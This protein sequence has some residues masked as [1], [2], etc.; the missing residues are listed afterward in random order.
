MAKKFL[1]AIRLL[2]LAEDPVSASNGDLY[3]NSSSNLAKLYSNGSWVNVPKNVEDLNNVSASGLSNNQILVYNQSL[4][5]W[6][7]DNLPPSAADSGTSLPQSATNG[8]FF[9]HTV[10]E[11]LYFYFDQW[12]SI[13]TEFVDLDGGD[14]STTEFALT[15]DGGDSSSSEFSPIYNGGTSFS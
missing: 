7:N 6:Q 9:Y 13:N 2:T 12:I 15:V 8:T 14:S 11:K 4:S 5:K 3:Y 10:E 1:S